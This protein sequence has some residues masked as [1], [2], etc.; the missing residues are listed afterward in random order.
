MAVGIEKLG[1]PSLMIPDLFLPEK[2]TGAISNQGRSIS[3]PPGLAKTTTPPPTPPA[4]RPNFQSLRES[5]YAHARRGSDPGTLPR[6]VDILLSYKSAVQSVV[7]ADSAAK[8]NVRPRAPSG[9]SEG[10]AIN[11]RTSPSATRHI[12][13]KIVECFY[14]W[15]YPGL[16]HEILGINSLFGNVSL[17]I[18]TTDSSTWHLL[19]LSQT[20]LRLVPCFI[21][22]IASM[23]ASVLMHTIT[24]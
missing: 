13:H 2:I 7:V 3:P 24:C 18:I 22:R 8:A 20:T 16:I 6:P 12:N 11:G 9:S 4:N 21:L 5:G 14:S 23:I 15:F 1:L 10:S 17:Q 19:C